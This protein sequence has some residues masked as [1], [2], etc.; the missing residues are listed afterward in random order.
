MRTHRRRPAAAL[1][2]LLLLVPALAACGEEE[3]EGD[4]PRTT[5]TTAPSTEDPAS[6]LS[7]DA[8]ARL[9]AIEGRGTPTPQATGTVD[10][11]QITDDV[12]GDGDEVTAEDTVT[13]HY[14]GVA[15]TSGETFDSSW[16]G[17]E[18]AT[19]PLSGVIAGW[20]EGM[21]GMKEGG[22]RT[23]VIPAELAYGDEGPAPG[24]S[25]VFTIDLVD[26]L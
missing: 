25:L 5:H 16:E 10:E 21:V 11:L 1:A 20:T 6:Q 26:I 8:Q 13:V 19:F 7:E 2:A 23:L 3:G 18:P 14:V 4:R 12:E 22:R 9:E 15:A 24:D 17:G